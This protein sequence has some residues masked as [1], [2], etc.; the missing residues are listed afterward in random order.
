MAPQDTAVVRTKRRE[1][2]RSSTRRRRYRHLDSVDSPDDIRALPADAMRP[3]CDDVREEL[4]DIVSETGG[5]L[6]SGLGV[7]ELTVALHRAF[8]TPRDKLIWDVSHQCY[9]HKI[10]TGRRAALRKLRQKGGPSGFT[11]ISES[12]FDPFGAAHSSTS[13]S[14]GLGFAAARDYEQAPHAVVAVIGDGAMSGGM[15]FEGLNN[16]GAEKRPMVIVLNDNAM[17][18][19]PPAGA[20]DRHLAELR[21]ILPD[22]EARMAALAREDLPSFAETPTLFDQFGVRYVGPFDGHDVEEMI[23]VFSRA[24]TYR[25][26]PLLVHVLT[27]KGK[28]FDHAEGADDRYHGVSKFCAVS[29][30]QHKSPSNA[31]SYTSVYANALIAEARKDDR[32]AAVS[33]AMP[34]G[35]GLDKFGAAFPDRCFD[36]GIA[37]QHAVTFCAGLA[38]EGYKPFATIY[39]TFLQRAYDQIVHDVALQRLP[40]RFAIDRAGMVGADGA[41]HQGAYDIAYLG[42]L[43]G[44]VLM[45]ASDE[46]EL[47]HMVATAAAIDDGPS[48][49]RYPRGAAVGIACPDEGAALE[50]GKGRIVREGTDAAILSFGARLNDVLTA[51]DHLEREGVLITV[52]DARFAKPIDDALVAQL[53]KD[54]P[55]VLTVEE[56]S[57]GGFATQVVDSLVR[58][59]RHDQ[60]NRLAPL[61][62]P[63]A[64]VDHDTPAGQIAATGLDAQGVAARV[65]ERLQFVRMGAVS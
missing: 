38:A 36:V 13:I 43:P 46:A 53:V 27:V 5:H 56:G 64:F 25:D 16:A 60:L 49:I 52:A 50:V 8:D 45:A 12:R 26:G 48:A 47:M 54:H 41:T 11:K 24:R 31:P 21:A 58:Q 6:G 35:T 63:D 19:A 4:I 61:Y 2:S 20:L 7:V 3:L 59:K 18:I 62:L 28:G 37:E 10:L 57:V 40:V 23:E 34:G 42:C 39:S 17:S 51:A 30:K 1:K 55:L 29:G 15:A 9:P 32:I 22:K 44:V 14:A 65:L 33:A